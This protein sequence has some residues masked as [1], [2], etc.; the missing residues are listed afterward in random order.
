MQQPLF[1]QKD[2]MI[3]GMIRWYKKLYVGKTV[4]KKEKK[5]RKS[6]EQGRPAPGIYLVTRAVNEQNQLEI[7]PAGYLAQKALCRSCPEII[8]IAGSRQEALEFVAR[9][10][11]EAY[12]K[13]G[14]ESIREYL[15][16]REV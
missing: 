4:K 12:R 10:A 16:A 13:R 3:V 11:D 15:E 9:L 14:C 7:L 6:I 1:R 5:I 8:G 2:G